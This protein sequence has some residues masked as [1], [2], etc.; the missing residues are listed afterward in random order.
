MI[1]E[2][3]VV[4]WPSQW[5]QRILQ[6]ELEGVGKALLRGT[7]K[8]IA[9]AV[10]KVK[11]LKEELL[12]FATS[13]VSKECSLLCSSKNTS[14][15]RK[16]NADDIA[17]LSLEKICKELKERAPFL[18]SILMTVGIPS[19]SVKKDVQWLPSVAAASSILLKERCRTMQYFQH[20]VNLEGWS[21]INILQ[22][23]V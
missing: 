19:Q 8:D 20:H 11:K 22:Q 4:T 16:C 15:L 21:F 9:S 2:Q 10:F 6:P 1:F 18:F 14:V 17:E 13:E 23:E 7:W 12:K 3:V 5:K